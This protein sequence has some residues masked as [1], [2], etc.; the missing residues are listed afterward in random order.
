MLELDRRGSNVLLGLFLWRGAVTADRER[1]RD[2]Q[3]IVRV[4]PRDNAS[5]KYELPL[6]WR[7]TPGVWKNLKITLEYERPWKHIFSYR[8][9]RSYRNT[10]SFLSSNV[11]CV[12]FISVFCVF[13][14]G[15]LAAFSWEKV[16]SCCSPEVCNTW[17]VLSIFILWISQ[18]LKYRYISILIVSRFNAHFFAVK[19]TTGV[20]QVA[21]PPPEVN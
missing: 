19:K 15:A 5:H 1:D 9:M 7:V 16:S 21:P 4:C 11:G 2:I 18:I 17:I 8:V 13:I 14:C 3:K 12:W 10:N 20:L 6:V